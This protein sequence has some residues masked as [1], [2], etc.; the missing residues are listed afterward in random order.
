MTTDPQ[1]KPTPPAVL[2]TSVDEIDLGP[3]TEK[4]STSYATGG[5][6]DPIE[7]ASNA[8][9]AIAFWLLAIVSGVVVGCFLTIWLGSRD[10]A[11]VIDLAG[12]LLTP[13]IG[14]LGAAT[15]FYYAQQKT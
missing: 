12:A 3:I 14:L 9:K 10:T 15:G 5:K 11:D 8:R 1:P 13:L 7:H 2:T 4:G 6:F